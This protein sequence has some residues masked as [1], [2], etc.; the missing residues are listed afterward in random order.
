M[1]ISPGAR[2][3]FRQAPHIIVEV[4]SLYTALADRMTRVNL[5]TVSDSYLP[6]NLTFRTRTLREI[7]EEVP[8]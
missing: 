4:L 1:N 8:Q 6:Q 2:L 7:M 3:R 5:Q